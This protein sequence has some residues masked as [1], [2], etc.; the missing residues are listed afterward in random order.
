MAPLLV[1]PL[2]MRAVAKAAFFK[3]LPKTSK[4]MVEVA[5]IAVCM[6]AGLPMALALK[7]QKMEIPVEELEEE[8]RN[9]RTNAGDAVQVVF[10][11]KGL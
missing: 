3:A 6:G 5:L 10:A 4:I 11:N 8:F 7:P 9:L 1:P 2:A